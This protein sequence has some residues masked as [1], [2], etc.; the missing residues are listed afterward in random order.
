M[1]VEAV[2]PTALAIQALHKGLCYGLC[3]AG[4]LLEQFFVRCGMCLTYQL[5]LAL[6][7]GLSLFID[8]RR[9]RLRPPEPR[10]ANSSGAGAKPDQPVCEQAVAFTTK[11]VNTGFGWFFGRFLFFLP[12]AIYHSNGQ[13]AIRMRPN[14]CAPAL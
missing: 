11:A 5:K 3:Q 10:R 4:R 9:A 6:G 2:V 12:K 8:A 7:K 14:L 1:G 13:S